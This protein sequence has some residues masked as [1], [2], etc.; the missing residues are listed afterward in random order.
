MH[1]EWF[2]QA[3]IQ[4]KDAKG[5]KIRSLSEEYA[6]DEDGLYQIKASIIFRHLK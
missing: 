5:E 6:Q 3:E 4:W 1:K 2:P